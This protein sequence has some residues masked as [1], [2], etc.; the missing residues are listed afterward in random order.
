MSTTDEIMRL[1][2]DYATLRGDTAV[3]NARATLLKAVEALAV[4]AARYRWLR[5]NYDD[6]LVMV[7]GDKGCAEMLMEK[8]LDRA[9]DS[10]MQK[11]TP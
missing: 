4:D 3:L 1:A 6:S 2:Y 5:L 9:V 8:E 7:G 11:E 10:A